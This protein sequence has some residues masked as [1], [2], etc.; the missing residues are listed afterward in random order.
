M[1]KLKELTAQPALDL[2]QIGVLAAQRQLPGLVELMPGQFVNQHNRP[3]HVQ[4]VSR[5]VQPLLFGVA[6][7]LQRQAV[8]SRQPTQYFSVLIHLIHSQ[9]HISRRPQK[10]PPEYLYFLINM[11]G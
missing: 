4:V 7:P 6:R 2:A 3:N 10:I 11:I 5:P 8:A 9:I 1:F